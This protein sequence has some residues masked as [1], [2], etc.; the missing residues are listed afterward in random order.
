MR[1]ASGRV[2]LFT[3]DDNEPRLT[4]FR[5]ARSNEKFRSNLRNEPCSHY[6]KDLDPVS[7]SRAPFSPPR[8]SL[9]GGPRSAV[10]RAARPEIVRE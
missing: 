6:A 1:K 4:R 9:G 7:D 10:K 2:G 5:I 3:R 8:K